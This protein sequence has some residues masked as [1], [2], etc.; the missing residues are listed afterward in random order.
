MATSFFKIIWEWLV[1]PQGNYTKAC[2]NFLGIFT[3]AMLVIAL[4]ISVYDGW[5]VSRYFW[6]PLWG[7]VAGNLLGRV[8]RTGRYQLFGVAL[9]VFMIS[10]YLL[11]VLTTNGYL[12]LILLALGS[13]VFSIAILKAVKEVTT[14]RGAGNNCE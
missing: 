6:F 2:A 10:F 9:L 8:R 7:M 13:A 1:K 3:I 5:E 4:L 14:S 12:R 11:V